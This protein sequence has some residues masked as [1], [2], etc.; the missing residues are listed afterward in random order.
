MRAFKMSPLVLPACRIL[1]VLI[2]SSPLFL[3]QFQY[4]NEISF[5]FF[6]FSPFN[7]IKGRNPQHFFGGGDASFTG[8]NWARGRCRILTWLL[9][10]LHEHFSALSLAARCL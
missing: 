4:E 6:F 10:I 9:R 5:F 2:Q 3:K 1:S 8:V 7:D